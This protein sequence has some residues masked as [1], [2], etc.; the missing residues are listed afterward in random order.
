MP[1]KSIHGYMDRFL[2]YIENHSTIE[3]F[4]GRCEKDIKTPFDVEYNNKVSKLLKGVS[5]GGDL[6]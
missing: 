2:F 5:K 3:W 4:S 1:F 6:K